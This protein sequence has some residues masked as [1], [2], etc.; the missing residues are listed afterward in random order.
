MST[1]ASGERSIA[2]QNITNAFTG[3]V[4]AV[5][6]PLEVQNAARDVQ[7]PPALSNLAPRPLCL[8][9]EDELTWLS[10]TL[11][12]DG[13]TAITQTPA[14]HGLG[15]IGKSTLA[16]DYAHRHRSDYTL[17]WWINADS[18]ARIEQSLAD[19]SRRLFPR[20]ARDASEQERAAWAT[21]WLQWHPGWL[22]VF[23]NVEDPRHL[24]PY[25]GALS[26][27][28]HLATSRRATG[29][30]A[31]TPTRAL[32]LLDPDEAAHLLCRRVLDRDPTPAER[33]DARRLAGDLGHLPLALEQAAAY[34]AETPTLTFE[35]YRQD[36]HGNLDQAPEGTDTERTIARV[37]TPTFQALRERDPKA[38]TLLHT[39]AWLAPDDIPVTILGPLV[40]SSRELTEALRL[41]RAYSTIT[42]TRDT[43]SIHRLV[44]TVLRSTPPTQPGAAPPGRREAEHALTHALDSTPEDHPHRDSLTP[45]LIALA[46]TTP[47]GHVRDT[48][49]PHYME[50]AQRLYDRGQDAR[51]IP[52]RENVLAQTEAALG[53]AHP[54]TLFSR[55]HLA[56]A[57]RTAGDLGRAIPLYESVLTQAE[58]VLGDTH[59]DT[60]ANRNN[61]ANAYREAGRL[62]RAIPLMETVLV[63]AEAT[64]GETHPDTL[65]S[66]NNLANAYRA[67]G[68]LGRATPLM[69]TVL[70]QAE[71]ILGDTHPNTLTSRNNLAGAYREAGDLGRAIPLY[72]TVLTQAEAILGDTHP[73][74][75]TSRN[76]LATAYQAAGD[77]DR[78]IHLHE[79]VLTQRE[80]LL[81]DTH[82]STLATRTNLAAAYQAAGR[83]DRAV[84]LLETTLTQ[85]EQVL[86]RT[87]PS[88]QTVRANLAH[89]RT[90]LDDPHG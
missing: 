54:A 34:L 79:T 5:V 8:G 41:L 57:Y 40:T 53:D 61:L 33:Q 12:A 36:L 46:A 65:A 25:T 24:A 35:E 83:L 38:V 77:L 4:W 63:Q 75:L 84:P 50:A 23:D 72:E 62:D 16:L 26:G 68:D 59:P 52:L 10:R 67:A 70:V 47:P 89:A 69:E 90:A 11:A 28:H 27:G 14:V 58:A 39:F 82:P 18:P 87:H 1:E 30:P 64:L 32:G 6:L 29:W 42:L 56:N 85:A 17:I 45:H 3:D 15:G 19:L 86:G 22:L 2:A 21:T 51:T 73:G 9:R 37:W 81:G 74:T 43:V 20:W 66:R 80:Q 31:T 78:A 88:T 71:A 55:N 13:E 76:N 60:L 44:Q 48:T 49:L 7:A